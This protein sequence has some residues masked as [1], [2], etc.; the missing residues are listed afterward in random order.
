MSGA[1]ALLP[2]DQF[3][4]SSSSCL[5]SGLNNIIIYWRSAQ[6]I[7]LNIYISQ[8]YQDIQKIK[9]LLAFNEDIFI[10]KLLAVGLTLIL[11][12]NLS[13]VWWCKII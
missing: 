10:K 12:D 3:G 8:R 1:H 13:D 11:L 2:S 5:Q 4:S 7:S 9:W 6:I